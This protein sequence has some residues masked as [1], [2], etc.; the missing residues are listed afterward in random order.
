VTASRTCWSQDRRPGCRLA[1]GRAGG[2]QKQSQA[3]KTKHIQKKTHRLAP[4]HL[5]R[6]IDA[7]APPVSLS[8]PC[9]TLWPYDARTPERTG[10]CIRRNPTRAAAPVLLLLHRASPSSQRRR[11]QVHWH[12]RLPLAQARQQRHRSASPLAQVRQQR[13]RS[14]SPLAVRPRCLLLALL[15]PCRAYLPVQRRRPRRPAPSPLGA[16]VDRLYHLEEA[17][18]LAKA[19]N[20]RLAAAVQLPRPAR[21]RQRPLSVGL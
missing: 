19:Q 21:A 8:A 9:C 12:Q 20:S 13:H 2:C 5:E 15:Q 11:P 16:P 17:Q 7:C 3:A 4:R 1:G 14:A 6:A 10:P 18:P